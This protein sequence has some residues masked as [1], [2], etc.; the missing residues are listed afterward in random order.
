MLYARTAAQRRRREA[1]PK[2]AVD[3]SR[4]KFA[5]VGRNGVTAS[6]SLNKNIQH[7]FASQADRDGTH[8]EKEIFSIGLF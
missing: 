4:G 1:R 8:Y 3:F 6:G 5:E 2:D 7:L